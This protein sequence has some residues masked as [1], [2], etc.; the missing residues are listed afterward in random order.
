M[1]AGVVNDRLE[2]VISLTVQGATG[3]SRSFDAVIDNRLW[4]IPDLA[5]EADR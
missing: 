1:I 2:A 4:R 5:A 3:Q